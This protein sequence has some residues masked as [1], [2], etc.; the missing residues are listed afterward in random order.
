MPHEDWPLGIEP[1][2]EVEIDL[3]R[4]EDA[5]GVA[6]LFKAVYGDNY[7]VK[8]YYDPGLLARENAQGRIIS[9]VVRTPRGEVVGH[10]ALFNS[11]PNP[12][13]YESGAGVVLPSYRN[14]AKLFTR[15]VDHGP[16]VTA[17]RFGIEAVFAD[18]L[19]AHVYSQKLCHG[20]GFI[21][22][23]MEVDMMPA[24][25]YDPRAGQEARVS[26]IMD[27]MTLVPKPHTVYLP[28]VYEQQLRFLYQGLDDSRELV[29]STGSA[30]ASQ[31]TRI[32]SQVYEFANLARLAV[33]EAGPGLVAAVEREEEAAF[34]R[35]V[36]VIQLW[37]QLSCPWVGQAV[38]QL[39]G[40]GYFL[41][42]LLPRWF[43]GD[44]L[45][46]LRMEHAPHWDGVR[47]EYDRA[48]EL[49][50]LVQED[51]RQV[52]GLGQATGRTS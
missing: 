52:R 27:F 5:P 20:L 26:T 13:L 37:L 46:M 15:M 51:W 38:E 24:Q 40:R 48:K 31:A 50:A 39:R 44:G 36:R 33:W 25:L 2:Q 17:Q 6:A 4:S 32:V 22:H 10:N 42:G 43:D 49:L 45:L 1:G 9:S 41:G 14:T 35:G 19:C 30:P 21:T 28:A 29:V 34:Q 18:P 11:A 16:Q 8:T 3:F 7:P 12:K 23:A 47:L